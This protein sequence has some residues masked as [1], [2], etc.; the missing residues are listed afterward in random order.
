MARMVMQLPDDLI[1]QFEEMANCSEEMIGEMTQAGAKLVYNNIINK[2]NMVFDNPKGLQK[3][4]QI[5]KVYKS[6]YDDGTNT[7]VAFYGYYKEGERTFSITKTLKSGK[8]A[9]YTYNGVPVP[10]IVMAREFGSSQGEAAKPFVLPSFN[11]SQI[12]Q[13]MLQKQNEFFSKKGWN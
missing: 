10:L 4:L 7:K 5:T 1:R 11:Q 3:H 9:T 13:A 8:K 6:K 12:R 2:M